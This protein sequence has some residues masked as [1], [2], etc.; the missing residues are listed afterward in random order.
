MAYQ[1]VSKGKTKCLFP[2]LLCSKYKADLSSTS[3]CEEGRS[4]R[5]R[6]LGYLRSHEP[7]S[8]IVGP[9][10]FIFS[11]L[12]LDDLLRAWHSTI[13]WIQVGEQQRNSSCP[14]DL[15]II[16][17]VIL[18]LKLRHAGMKLCF[19]IIQFHLVLKP[20]TSFWQQETVLQFQV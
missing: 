13:P 8:T 7:H 5:A 3:Q 10:S 4:I 16:P 6:K 15:I 19:S 14:K 18:F 9:F 1:L 20:S 17:G 11:K 12:L 2:L